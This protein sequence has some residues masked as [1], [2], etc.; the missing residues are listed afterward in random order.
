[1]E[2]IQEISN[3]RTHDLTDPEKTLRMK[4]SS[5]ATYLVRSVGIRSHSIFD[6]NNEGFK[7]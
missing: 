5:I 4:N 6:G 3:G 2:T 1:M 7:P